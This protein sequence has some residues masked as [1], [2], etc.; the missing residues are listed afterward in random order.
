MLHKPAFEYLLRQFKRGGGLFI[1]GAGASTG[2]TP[3]GDDFMVA[4]ALE[5]VFN[6]GSFPVTVPQQTELN[7]RI[8][9]KTTPHL[10]R[11]AV[12]DGRA[13]PP[14][15]QE[16]PFVEMAQRLPALFART[17]LKHSIAKPRYERVQ[18]DNYFVFGHFAPSL[19]LNY[20]LDGLLH[21]ARR[22]G[23]VV[24]DA[25]GTVPVGYGSPEVADHLNLLREYELPVPEDD[26]VL[27]VTERATDMALVKRLDSIPQ[28]SPRFIA[29]V[30]YS[31][32]R[33]GD[34]FDD[35]I[36]MR[37]LAQRFR[38]SRSD[39]YVI[40]PWP[41]RLQDT[42]AVCLASNCVHAIPAYWNLLSHAF[43]ETLTGRRSNSVNYL[44]EEALDRCGDRATFLH[45]E[46]QP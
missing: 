45:G 22:V 24:I 8:I 33:N 6:A 14:A 35:W 38:G 7:S 44:S 9:S 13:L 34:A 43:V 2:I 19:I 42:I 12:F 31:F 29:L 23:H 4:P 15:G 40:D 28:F 3:F 1:V 27:S 16:F 17:K 41:H 21:T 36:S 11:G 18:R 32:A 20:N 26:L 30:G 5:Y 10:L 37:W 39:I 46:R 25:H